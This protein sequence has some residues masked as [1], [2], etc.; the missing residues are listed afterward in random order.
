MLNFSPALQ[1]NVK[2]FLGE[3]SEESPPSPQSRDDVANDP[4]PPRVQR[5][6]EA[7]MSIDV[8][9][10][11]R[12][13]LKMLGINTDDF[14]LNEQTFRYMRLELP[15]NNLIVGPANAP[16]FPNIVV[17]LPYVFLNFI[18]LL[19]QTPIKPTETQKLHGA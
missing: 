14:E 11:T 16:I 2:K 10:Q 3:H 17:N 6:V 9:A 18:R 4:S 7:D 13:Q 5:R 12:Q 8:A 1:G 15:S 19:Y